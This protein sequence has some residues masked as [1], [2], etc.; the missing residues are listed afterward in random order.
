MRQIDHLKDSPVYKAVEEEARNL[1]KARSSGAETPSDH[2]PMAEASVQGFEV[3]TPAA[4]ATHRDEGTFVPRYRGPDATIEAIILQTMRP[5]YLIKNDRIELV[6][7]YDAVDLIEGNKKRLE[8]ISKSVGRVDLLHHATHDFVGTGWLID[9]EIVATNRHVA[10]LFAV[11]T[12]AGDYE[13]RAGR[14]GEMLEARLD[15]V[16]QHETRNIHRQA[17]VIDI[18]FISGPREPDF[19]F[20][21][22]KGHDGLPPLELRTKGVERNL[23]VA[24]IGYPAW[25]GDRNDPGWMDDLFGGVY[26]VKRFSPGFITNV[27]DGGILLHGDY[28]SLGGNSGSAVCGLEDGK[29]V[30]LHFAGVFRETNYMVAAD[31]VESARREL[32]T[33]VAVPEGLPE[34][35]KPTPADRFAGRTGYDPDFLGNGSFSV[36]MP[37][38]GDWAGKVAPVAG[39]DDG[40]LRYEHFST[41]QCATRRLPLLTAVNIDGSQQKK[42]GRNGEWKLDGRIEL[43]HQVGNELYV[44]NALDRGHMVRRRDPGWGDKASAERGELDTFHY[45]NSVPQHEDLNQKTW[46]GLEDYVLHAAETHGFKASVFTGP[47][48]RDTD[49]FLRNQPGAEDVA[50]PEEFW[51]IVVMVD[52]EERKLHVTAYILSHGALLRDMTE[53]PFLYGKHK[54]Y[55][56]PVSLVERGTGL[57]FG[58]L[59]G[60]D[61][62]ASGAEVLPAFEIADASDLVL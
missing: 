56:V 24:A 61:P 41:V 32:K 10:N 19:A 29:V 57:D 51:K 25:D 12:N 62:L 45:T 37:G 16:R 50:I 49:R 34:E 31:V 20:L 5:A 27:E 38:F 14:S 17:T 2:A 15:F 35:A 60:F 4:V 8:E 6:G 55:Q 47:V 13:F 39:A 11:A 54:T 3:E 1:L 9:D 22:V 52:A 36:P 48:F 42:L 23:P 21:R 7:K 26:K 53:A 59:R 58:A 30:G 33:W 46:V 43:A 40:I 44:R 28:T 18:L